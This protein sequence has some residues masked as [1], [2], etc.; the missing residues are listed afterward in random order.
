MKIKLRSICDCKGFMVEDKIAT[1][2]GLNVINDIMVLVMLAIG[3]FDFGA[4]QIA[5]GIS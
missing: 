1:Q 5:A 4:V 2:T 3:E